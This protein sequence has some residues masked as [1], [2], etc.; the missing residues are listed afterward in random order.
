MPPPSDPLDACVAAAQAGNPAAAERLVEHLYPLVQRIVHAH[1]PRRMGEDDLVQE[2]FMKMLS[3]LGDYRSMPG[4]PIDHWAARLAVRTCLDHL[5][6]ERRRPEL[7]WS[8]LSERSQAWLEYLRADAAQPPAASAG[9]TKEVVDALLDRLPAADR[10]V[11]TLLDLEGH[12]VAEIAKLTGW[13]ASLV[14]VRAF[15]AR[16]RLRALVGARP[17]EDT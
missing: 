12:P 9:E 14:K 10:L 4:I 16:H 6:A 13:S 1:R 7:R 2:V 15:R 3:R 11:L 17:S 5:R 8:D